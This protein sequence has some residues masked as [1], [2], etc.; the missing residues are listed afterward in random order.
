M[1]VLQIYARNHVAAGAIIYV[2]ALRQQKLLQLLQL[3]QL[4]R[5]LP[6]LLTCDHLPVS[7]VAWRQS[8]DY[9]ASR[10]DSGPTHFQFRTASQSLLRIAQ[11]LSLSRWPS[12]KLI[13]ACIGLMACFDHV[14]DS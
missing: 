9:E 12:C 7:K 3:L 5:Q 4:L 14:S 6:K 10:F 2:G 13:Q 1:Y 11:N 8:I